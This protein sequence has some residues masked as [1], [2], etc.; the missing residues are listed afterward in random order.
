MDD[1]GSF[2]FSF[3]YL[4]GDVFMGEKIKI[5]SVKLK[6]YIKNNW[7]QPRDK[8]SILAVAVVGFLFFML[9]RVEDNT[10]RN[11]R[12]EMVEIIYKILID[13]NSCTSLIDCQKKSYFFVSPYKSG[14]SIETY[15]ISSNDVLKSI[16]EEAAKMFFSNEKMNILISGYAITK[17]EDM[18]YI[19]SGPRPVYQIQFE[20][21]DK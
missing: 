13:S 4:V 1:R 10:Y 14:I 20:R 8:W 6:K 3:F 9:A 21:D 17:A 18:T 19:F 7:W 11:E 5:Y 2:Y 12:L 16:T 15:A